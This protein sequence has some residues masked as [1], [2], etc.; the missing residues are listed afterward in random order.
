MTERI[1]PCPFCGEK[2]RLY[3]SDVGVCV[4]C[5]GGFKTGCACQTEWF[6]DVSYGNGTDGWRNAKYTATEKAVV[7]WNRR[8]NDDEA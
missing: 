6:D 5:T 3:V 1:K 4:K 2:A 8:G 7:A